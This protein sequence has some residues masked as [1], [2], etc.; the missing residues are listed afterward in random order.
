MKIIG[1]SA[2]ARENKSTHFLLEH[3]LDEA[4]RAAEAA[5]KSLEVELID[6]APLKFQK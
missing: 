2:S 3:C 6:L 1:V 4:K 5:G